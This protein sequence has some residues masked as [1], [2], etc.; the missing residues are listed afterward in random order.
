MSIS[1]SNSH[2]KP[3]RWVISFPLFAEDGT[4]SR[5]FSGWPKVAK[6]RS[7]L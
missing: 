4:K 7:R 3:M 5:E 6:A 1:S 2:N